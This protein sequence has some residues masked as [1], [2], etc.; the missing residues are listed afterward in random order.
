MRCA[1]ILSE[2]RRWHN[3]A[4]GAILRRMLPALLLLAASA[5]AA[6]YESGLEPLEE[7]LRHAPWEDRLRIVRTLTDKGPAGR[8]LLKLAARD[9]DWQV[10]A[11][12]A[13]AL[14]RFQAGGLDELSRLAGS[15]RCR[16]VRLAAA[17]Q[18]GRLGRSA[19]GAAEG[20]DDSSECVSSYLPDSAASKVRAVK[21]KDSTRPD[22]AGCSYLRFQRLGKNMCPKGMTVHGIGRPPESPKLLKVRGEDAGVAF[23]C[24]SSE[25]AAPEPVEVECRLIP[26]DCPP[27]WAQMDEPADAIT[28]KEGRY[29]RDERHAQGD[30]TWVQ[31][32]RPVP[33][34]KEEGEEVAQAAE[35]P[36]VRRPRR[37][38]A[39]PP[40]AEPEPPEEEPPPRTAGPSPEALI[41]QR[42]LERR[43]PPPAPPSKRPKESL[44][45]PKGPP[46]REEAPV[47]ASA[48]RAPT[49]RDGADSDL[50]APLGEAEDLPAP[51]GAPGREEGEVSA[52]AFTEAVG[53]TKPDSALEARRRLGKGESALAAPVGP[54]G[55]DERRVSAAADLQADAGTKLSPDDPL[56]V[57]LKGLA[58][59]EPAVRA[60]AA[61]M[62]GSRGT[63]AKG[64][65]KAL[66]GAL[67]DPSARVRS[68]AALALGS[69]TAGGDE[70]VP[71][72]KKL[73]RDP[74]PDVRYSAASAL[75]RVG[76]KA[77]DRAFSGYMRNE[78][79]R[80]GR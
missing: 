50:A 23:C 35:P 15:D 11:A 64:A 57:L 58:A 17:H 67:K 6:P 12:A 34:E 48:D 22:E 68:D 19:P 73:L 69:V 27:P 7:R 54:A 40:E 10:R 55:R 51:A 5:F 32:C 75:G 2:M 63:D 14:G 61:Q 44:P 9:S 31:C 62:I 74:H 21:A 53:R 26:E 65:A 59:P 4:P 28:G 45:A 60:L 25:A 72:L 39:P 1:E 78:A 38:A 66:L 36:P 33:I 30:L 37:K 43:E 24:P 46:P 71:G 79:R 8:D 16:L 13:E 20:D 76:T 42:L 47:A 70:A 41:A 18:L 80:G 56:P 52:S 77:A 3:A 29:R 49:D